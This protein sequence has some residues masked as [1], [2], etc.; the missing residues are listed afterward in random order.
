MPVCRRPLRERRDVQLK[1]VTSP[2]KEN[3]IKSITSQIKHSYIKAKAPVR[4]GRRLRLSNGPGKPSP[5]SRSTYIPQVIAS[6]NEIKAPKKTVERGRPKTNA[7]PSPLSREL[8]LDLDYD[9]EL[10]NYDPFS[11]QTPIQGPLA[12]SSDPS[13]RNFLQDVFSLPQDG[14]SDAGSFSLAY[15]DPN[16]YSTGEEDLQSMH[17]FLPFLFIAF[18]DGQYTPA[19]LKASYGIDFSHI[20]KIA[21]PSLIENE[22]PGS[23]FT[24]V[25]KKTG[26]Q[27]LTLTI[28]SPHSHSRSSSTGSA[29]GND[30]STSPSRRRLKGRRHART[31]ISQRMY[32]LLTEEQLLSVRDFLSLA[33]PYY[34]EAR[35]TTKKVVNETVAVLVTAPGSSSLKPVCG[36]EDLNGFGLDYY[37]CSKYGNDGG[38]ADIIS[39]IAC[40]LSFASETPAD[41]V[42]AYIDEEECLGDEWKDAVSRDEDGVGYIQQV[43]AM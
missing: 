13:S 33:L 1:V 42:L 4:G 32:T 30:L 38:A 9:T 41:M 31:G 37:G 18:S 17:E 24:S 5:G 12:L 2:S 40:Y 28:P 15:E 22:H 10:E 6:E 29:Y 21:Y 11:T 26:V 3:D 27:T 14:Y 7:A 8:N 19:S 35:P 39:A 25:N 34:L 23:I 20:V 36:M 16:L 43:A